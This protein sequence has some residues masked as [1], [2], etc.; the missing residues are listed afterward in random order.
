[1]F[2]GAK[3]EFGED[4]LEAV[5]KFA[6]LYMEDC[7]LLVNLMLPR[8]GEVLS[9]QRGIFY[10]FGTHESQFPVFE[11][12]PKVNQA[13]THNLQLERE[14]GDHDQRITRKGNV[15]AA[16]RDNILKRT[17]NLR[18]ESNESFRVPAK[19][20]EKV[21]KVLNEWNSRQEKLKAAGLSAKESTQLLKENRK[22]RILSSLKEDNGPFTCA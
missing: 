16:S 14:C 3:S 6:E 5:R 17:V 13:I 12:S 9:Q 11:Q 20:V 7:I 8:L 1:M 21:K 2:A 22:M 4:V 18:D 15:A 10:G 19:T